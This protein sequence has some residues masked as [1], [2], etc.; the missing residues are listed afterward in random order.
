[1]SA[2]LSEVQLYTLRWCVMFDHMG[3]SCPAYYGEY[4]AYEA[5]RRRRLVRRINKSRKW[6]R[7]FYEAT[8]A[9]RAAID[10][11]NAATPRDVAKET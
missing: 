7:S 8:D 11:S 10:A 6:E 5:L 9:G 1:M 2:K 4:Q 3:G